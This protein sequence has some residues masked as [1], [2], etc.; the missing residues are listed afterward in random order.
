MTKVA[1][2]SFVSLRDVDVIVTNFKKRY[3]GVTSTIISLVPVQQKS[4]KIAVL[5]T[6]AADGW[7]RVSWCGIWA[8]GWTRPS[9]GRPF[10]IWHARRNHE[11]LIGVI[12][13][14]ILRMKLKLVFTSAA[15]RDHTAWTKFLLRKMDAVIATSPESGSFLEVPHTV[16]LHGIV[17]ERY[18]PAQNRAQEWAATGLPG[19]YGV[20]VFGR[21]R[22]QK[23]TD[24]FVDALC[25]LLP[26]HPDFTAVIIGETT[27]DQMEFKRALQKKIAD[28]GL[29]KRIIFLG[30]QPT[31]ELPA[32]LRRMTIVVCPQ[33]NEGFGL[34]PAE[35]MS[36]GAAVVATRVGAAPHLIVDGQTGHL[37]D[38][39]DMTA[40]TAHLHNLM[41]EPAQ[42]EAMGRAGREH[43]AKNFSIEREAT[44][45]Q[46]VYEKLW[47]EAAE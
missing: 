12:L 16:N 46:A 15:Q 3:T 24:R 13:R 9:S 45:I 32:W 28:S 5:G 1:E 19:K 37:V 30:L 2:Q 22:H 39:D 47:T 29:E 38:V 25:E 23:G 27:P 34:V 10:R 33:R 21:V 26:Q 14:D 36:S 35:A 8:Y 43:I 44:G 4:L 6:P 40:L 7:P 42:A 20:G 41:S 17:T 11:M 18:R 31:E